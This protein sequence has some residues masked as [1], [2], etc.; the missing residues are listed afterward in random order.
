MSKKILVIVFTGLFLTVSNAYAQIDRNRDALFSPTAALTFYEAAQDI[1]NGSLT[2]SEISD[3]KA[4]L[5]LIFLTTA[6]KLDPQ[7]EYAVTDTLKVACQATSP[8]S[9]GLAHA[10][11][12]SK[13]PNDPNIIIFAKDNSDLVK[14]LLRSYVDEDSDMQIVNEAIKYLLG[15]VDSREEKQKLLNDLLKRFKNKNDVLASDIHLKLGELALEIADSNTATGHFFEAYNKNSYNRLAFEKFIQSPDVNVLVINY[16]EN[17][18]NSLAENPLDIQTAITFGSYAQRYELFQ[19]AS[20]AYAYAAKLYGYLYEDKPLPQYIYLPWAMNNYSSKRNPTATLQ[21][22]KQVR[23]EETF[24]LMLEVVAAKTA[25][26]IQ[27]DKQAKKILDDAEK[28]TL[29]LYEA[30]PENKKDLST[31][32]A[33]LYCFGKIEPDKAID[34]ANKAYAFDPNSPA[35]AAILAYALVMNDQVEFAKQFVD[36]YETSLVLELVKAKIQLTDPNSNSANETLRSIIASAPETLEA[37]IARELLK[38]QGSEYIPE[39]DPKLMQSLLDETFKNQVIPIF[40][41]PD[42][43]FDAKLNIRGDK[44]SYGN[45]FRASLVITNR[46]TEPLI[47]SDYGLFQGNIRVAAKISGDLN[48]T[49]EKLLVKRILPSKHVKAN[50]SLIVPI[51]LQTGELKKI[52]QRYPQASLEIEF[53]VYLDPV[54]LED[55][56]VANRLEDIKPITTKVKRPGIEITGQFLRNRMNSLRR[57]RQSHETAGLFSGLLIEHSIMAGHEPL[58]PYKFTD[59]MDDMLVSSI[60]YNLRSDEWAPR[61]HTMYSL[62]ELPLDFE[63]IEAVSENLNDEQWPVR[64]MALYVL[65]RN[66]NGFSK[67]LDYSAKYDDVQLVKDT[68]VAM[69]GTAPQ[70]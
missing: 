12:K 21:I 54:T 59:W 53:T 63:I 36:N 46:S 16:F 56:T 26:D 14:G 32:I 52:M 64:M 19:V 44:F 29:S 13:D 8:L 65:G 9:L 15:Q 67:V 38:E 24:D 62:L 47:I 18:R 20:E 60:A 4:E 58:Y 50:S 66:G 48:K 55:S 49:I 28:K 42:E 11:G 34:W 31:Q 22:A 57:R 69:G 6:L 51:N 61:V 27:S 35:A 41:R 70:D 3:E 43:I 25:K 39:V 33:W 2:K 45:D 30:N 23:D 1:I 40:T 17:F 68:A 37:E 5:A 7:A 10:Y